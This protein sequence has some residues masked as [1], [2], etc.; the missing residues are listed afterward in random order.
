MIELSLFLEG[1]NAEGESIEW[2]WG[3][4][5]AEMAVVPR[6]GETMILDIARKNGS[7]GHVLFKVFDIQHCMECGHDIY[8]MLRSVDVVTFEDWSET[9]DFEHD[10]VDVDE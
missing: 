4:I 2:D 9:Q 8:V 7:G 6:I 5:S 10:C 1:R 3:P